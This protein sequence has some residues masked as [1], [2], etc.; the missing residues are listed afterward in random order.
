M[1]VKWI[2]TREGAIVDISGGGQSVF[3]GEAYSGGISFYQ[4]ETKRTTFFH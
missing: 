3:S 2:F 4:L 1:V